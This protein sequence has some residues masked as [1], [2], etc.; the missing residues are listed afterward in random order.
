MVIAR[1]HVVR[2]RNEWLV[3]RTMSYRLSFPDAKQKVRV[4]C[5]GL[6]KKRSNV[7]AG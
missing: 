4:P 3:W 1:G 6:Q 5:C 2:H 7:I